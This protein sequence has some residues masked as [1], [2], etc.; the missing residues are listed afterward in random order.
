MYKLIR[1]Y[2]QNRK[3]IFKIILIIVFLFGILQLLN[4]FAKTKNDNDIEGNVVIQS[5]NQY[6]NS[7]ISNKSAVSGKNVS[8]AKLND[9]TKVI[10]NFFDYCNNGNIDDAYN[11]LTD[12]CKE[13]MYPT[14]EDFKNIYY[15]YVFDG[16]KKSYSMENWSGDIYQV[17]ITGDILETG[18]LDNA[19]TK[20]DYITVIDNSKL[21]ING[22]VGRKNKDKITEYKDIKVKVESIDTYMDYE[23]YN[24]SVENNTD[25]TI[26]MDTSDDTQSVYLLDSKNM[27]YYFYGNEVIQN[28]LII[29]SKFSNNLKIKFS[30]SY[31]SSRNINKLV[32]SKVVLNYEEYNEIKDKTEYNDFCKL[33]VDI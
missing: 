32:F 31:S 19:E 2:N 10:K 17:K 7:V 9:D 29:Q 18:K 8:N 1:F 5:N 21:N 27:K 33:V 23:I 14:I 30:N 12:E 25:K 4:F 11:L 13:E 26:M 22:Y 20:Q 3:K 28:K 6:S 16:K 15:L 24:L